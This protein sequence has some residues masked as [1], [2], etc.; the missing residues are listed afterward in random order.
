[1]SISVK[2]FCLRIFQN[3]YLTI[4]RSENSKTS[5]YQIWF[6]FFF[7]DVD[8]QHKFT[9]KKQACLVLKTIISIA[10][11]QDFPPS[12]NL[13][14]DRQ[15]VRSGKVMTIGQSDRLA[16]TGHQATTA[17]LHSEQLVVHDTHLQKKC[18]TREQY[19]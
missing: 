16:L 5:I 10:P 18:K 19:L 6:N 12:H 1:M 3:V 4:S 8:N 9:L 2:Y 13:E 7:K 15:S 11:Y 14:E 17:G